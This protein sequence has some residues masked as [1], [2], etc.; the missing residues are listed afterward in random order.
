MP[1]C[2]LWRIIDFLVRLL[3]MCVETIR[4]RFTSTLSTEGKG[5][6]GNNGPCNPWGQSEQLNVHQTHGTKQDIWQLELLTSLF[7]LS[8]SHGLKQHIKIRMKIS[9]GCHPIPRLIPGDGC[10]RNRL[11]QLCAAFPHCTLQRCSVAL[12][13]SSAVMGCW[14]LF[15]IQSRRNH[16][17]CCWKPT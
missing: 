7:F 6:K 12:R 1:C 4:M 5:C 13:L 14:R 17:F 11:L 8:A 9:L 2:M 3:A 15:S 16:C 10:H